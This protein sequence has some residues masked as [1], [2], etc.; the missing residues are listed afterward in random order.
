[1]TTFKDR[2]KVLM[3]GEKPYAW[4]QKVGIE[5]GIFQYY[6][7]KERIPS[8]K[9]LLKIQQYT[10]CS[11]D[12]LVTGKSVDMGRVSE[13]EMLPGTLLGGKNK[14]LREKRSKHFLAMAAKLKTIYAKG[15]QKDLEALEYFVNAIRKKQPSRPRHSAEIS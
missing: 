10:G 13:Q 11:L 6:W 2:L 9:N 14:A 7:Q 3:K 12:W 5:K 1:M 8:C 15:D 4:T